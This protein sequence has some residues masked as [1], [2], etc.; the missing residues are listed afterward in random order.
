MSPIYKIYRCLCLNL[1][2]STLLIH[3]VL[4]LLLTIVQL[5][6]TYAQTPHNKI[7]GGIEIGSK[8]VKATVIELLNDEEGYSAKI[9]FVETENTGITAGLDKSGKF[10]T[11]AIEETARSVKKFYLAM[12]EKLN[13][14]IDNIFIIGSSGL[15]AKNNDEL[16]NRVTVLTGKPMAFINVDEE[17]KLTIAGL[18]PEKYSQ[19]S[20][21]MDIGSGN[22]KGG[23]RVQQTASVQKNKSLV[24][25]PKLHEPKDDTFVTVSVPYGTVTLSKAIGTINKQDAKS[26]AEQADKIAT[27]LIEIPL[28]EQKQRKAGLVN[29]QKVYLS[30]GIVW[31]MATLMHPGNRRNFVKLM[32]QDINSFYQMI[33]DNPTALLNQNLSKFFNTK[34]R[35]GLKNMKEAEQDLQKIKDTFTQENLIA[36]AKILQSLSSE[37]EFQNKQIYFARQGYIAWIFSY[38]ADKA[39]A[40]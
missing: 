4:L 26:Y 1:K 10:S 14:P 7:F 16:Q 2:P 11:D 37:F 20:L 23:Y 30:G 15:T 40:N 17:V 24:P 21:L 33:V 39:L 35:V 19:I 28:R 31:A 27:E 9:L 22:T 13:V 32:P 29:R 6:L 5:P 36:G 8:G 25:D 3:S 34:S 12:Q 18:V 38:I